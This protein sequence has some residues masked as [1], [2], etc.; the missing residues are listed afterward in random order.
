MTC[1]KRA[2]QSTH[3]EL[4]PNGTCVIPKLI[5]NRGV[6]V[7][8]TSETPPRYVVRLLCDS[9]HF[10]EEVFRREEID[11]VE[12]TDGPTPD[13]T[14]AKGSQPC[15]CHIPKPALIWGP[16]D[17]RGEMLTQC[18]RFSILVNAGE[19]FV[20]HDNRYP[21]E[22][23]EPFDAVGEAQ[24]W[25]LGR[26]GVPVTMGA[27]TRTRLTWAETGSVIV[28]KCGRFV[29]HRDGSDRYHAADTKMSGPE[30]YSPPGTLAQS[31]AWCEVRSNYLV[32]KDGDKEELIEESLIPF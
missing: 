6:V 32:C 23:S 7:A 22:Y 31:K 27:E 14:E 17:S 11:G 8:H 10:T 4:I 20:A 30:R 25:C 15:E 9:S 16:P 21:A 5:R 1:S 2:E 24:E 28:S 29:V 26:A 3:S 18:R 13:P 19:Q 12:L